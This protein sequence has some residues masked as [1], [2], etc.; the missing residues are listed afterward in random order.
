MTV[1]G[2]CVLLCLTALPAW[3]G[4]SDKPSPFEVKTREKKKPR[5]ASKSQDVADQAV[6]PSGNTGIATYFK[7]SANGRDR[8]AS[9]EPVDDDDLTAAHMTLPLGSRVR[10]VNLANNRSV[11]VRITDR[12]SFAAGR[13]ISVNY[14]AA[15]ELDFLKSGTA[16]V[17]LEP[18]E[19]K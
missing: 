8:T 13:I 11:V 19:K 17:R 3:C 15:R 2:L 5:P 1:G 9:G 16:R 4:Q 12:G 18:V 10:V 7:A 6:D 14:R